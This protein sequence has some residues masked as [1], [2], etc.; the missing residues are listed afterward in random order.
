MKGGR[1]KKNLEKKQVRQMKHMGLS[2]WS[3]YLPESSGRGTGRERELCFTM[4]SISRFSRWK[5]VVYSVYTATEV[6]A[7]AVNPLLNMF[8]PPPA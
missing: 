1:R 5:M 8:V 2:P 3:S 4:S 6:T 7:P